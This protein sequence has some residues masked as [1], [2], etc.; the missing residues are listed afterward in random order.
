MGQDTGTTVQ[1]PYPSD[2][3]S[4]QA[5]IASEETVP[6][7]S[8]ACQGGRFELHEQP[9]VE[10]HGLLLVGQALLVGTLAE[11]LRTG[12]RQPENPSMIH[13]L[14]HRDTRSKLQE[15]RR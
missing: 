13:P 9:L 11:H 2:G 1:A 10:P 14:R 12:F 15:F 5:G 7:P 4:L 8:Q 6:L 3:L